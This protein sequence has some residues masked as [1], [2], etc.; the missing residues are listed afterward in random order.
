MA[1]DLL[2]IGAFNESGRG[3]P[4]NLSRPGAALPFSP[5]VQQAYAPT[6]R[7]RIGWAAG[8]LECRDVPLD[9]PH[10]LAPGDSARLAAKR[11][12]DEDAGWVALLE[13]GRFLGVVWADAVL[14]CVADDR[15]P[16]NVG[17]LISSQIPTCAPT[18]ALV[19]AVRQMIA[20]WIRRIP[21]VGDHGEL[22]G[23]LPLAAAAQAAGRDPAVRDVLESAGPDLFARRWR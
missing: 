22:V 21:V 13:G 9:D 2:E 20:T 11:M 17:W 14:R 19:D 10:G 16:S 23:I 3:L 4:I 7:A 5:L 15:L 18:S 1:D 12:L 6:P 8:L